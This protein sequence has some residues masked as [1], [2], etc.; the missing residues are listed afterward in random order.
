MVSTYNTRED[1]VHLQLRLGGEVTGVVRSAGAPLDIA[2]E[3][4]LV[5]VLQIARKVIGVAVVVLRTNLGCVGDES[6][7]I[8]VVHVEDTLVA[9]QDRRD[10]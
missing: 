3:M 1:V 7:V 5:G 4:R 10:E 6:G 9:L 2:E 8:R